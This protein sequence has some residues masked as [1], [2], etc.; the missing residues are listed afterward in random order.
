[1]DLPI[2]LYPFNNKIIALRVFSS[3]THPCPKYIFGLSFQ[4]KDKS[5]NL[6]YHNE[7]QVESGDKKQE[8]DSGT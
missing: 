1:M 5:R 2:I 6:Y 7:L 3:L 8:N 4:D